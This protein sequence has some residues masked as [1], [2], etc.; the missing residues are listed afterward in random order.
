MFD[1]SLGSPWRANLNLSA[2]GT[3]TL[4]VTGVDASGVYGGTSTSVFTISPTAMDVISN[5]YDGNGNVTQRLWLDSLGHTNRTQTL[6]WDAFV[7]RTFLS[8]YFLPNCGRK[9]RGFSAS[10]V[11][12]TDRKLENC[13]IKAA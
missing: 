13:R 6:T 2:G 3:H 1:G 7:L 4:Q 5:V 10:A 11:V 12:K 9:N 8:S